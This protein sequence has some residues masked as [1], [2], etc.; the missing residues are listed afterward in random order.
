MSLSDFPIQILRFSIPRNLPTIKV[1][2]VSI[3]RFSLVGERE[4]EREGGRETFNSVS[5]QE[6]KSLPSPEYNH[7]QG[8]L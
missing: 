6:I 7:F 5:F 2:Q 1:S 8:E 3:S 4:R